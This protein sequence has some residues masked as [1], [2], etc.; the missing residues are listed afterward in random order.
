MWTLQQEERDK[1][2]TFQPRLVTTKYSAA[3]ARRRCLRGVQGSNES[4]AETEKGDGGRGC[5]EVEKQARFEMLY[6]DVSP[7]RPIRWVASFLIRCFYGL[8]PSMALSTTPN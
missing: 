5:T 3:A 2:L 6:Q 1:E 7:Y 4:G 8:G